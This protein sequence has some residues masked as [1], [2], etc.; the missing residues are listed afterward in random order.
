MLCEGLERTGIAGYPQE[1]APRDDTATWRDFHCFAQHVE[2]FYR[3]PSLCRTSNGVVG[4]KLMWN[5]FSAWGLDICSYLRVDYSPS[6]AIRLMIGPFRVIRLI[7]RDRLRQAISWIRARHSGVWSHRFRSPKNLQG[8]APAYD[9]SA[10]LDAIGQLD[11]QNRAWDAHIESIGAPAL[12]IFYEDLAADYWGTVEA[13]TRVL[14]LGQMAPQRGSPVL[15]RQA[16]AVTEEWVARAR[17]DLGPKLTAPNANIAGAI[18]ETP[19]VP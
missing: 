4:V 12:T 13:V 17:A 3:F 18:P 8:G 5:Q 1:Y 2:Y 19:N 11:E 10:I 7:R 15:A 14:G 16:D 9:A 6:E